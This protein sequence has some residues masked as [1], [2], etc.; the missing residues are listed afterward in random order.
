MDQRQRLRSVGIFAGYM[1]A[2]VVICMVLGWFAARIT[3]NRLLDDANRRLARVET[4]RS[5][6]QWHLHKPRDLIAGRA[7]GHAALAHNDDTLR[8]T[9][10]DGTPF[11]LGLPVE[12]A[13][14][15]A[16]WPIL[17]VQLES[18]APGTLGLIWGSDLTPTCQ[19]AVASALTPDTRTLRIDLR[20]LRW[21]PVGASQCPAPGVARMLR[22]TLQIPASA[23]AQL[24]S[25]ALLTTEPMMPAPGTAIDL[26][27]GHVEQAFVRG[28]NQAMPWFRLPHG[29][30]AENM[31]SLR[32]QLLARWPGALILPAGA[33]PQAS[34][35]I[36]RTTLW[37]IACVLYLVALAWLAARP[38]KGPPRAWLE[39]T[40][41]LL[42]PLW[43]VIGLH[44]GLYPT[45]LG[46][47]AFGGGLAY[48]FFIE[49]RHLPRLWRW[50]T[51][52][53]DWLWPSLTVPVTLVLIATR[54]HALHPL[55]LGH[56]LTYFA[57]AW[58]QQWLMLIV[59]LP[60]VEQ[61]TRH[62]T[63]PSIIAVA[64]LFALLHTPNGMLMQ[65]CFIAELWWAWCFRRSRSV[66]PIGLAHA[67]CALL[68]ES[69]LVGG[70]VRSLEVSARFFL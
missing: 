32:D 56:V 14:D 29:L 28:G 8:I 63:A 17:Q 59:L 23:S 16:H 19:I 20:S 62:R 7:F 54:G 40:G 25:A 38:I 30:S 46:I 11:E 13:L 34:P 6:W 1:L 2:A 37:W 53:R 45:A 70:L 18:S 65:L 26:P 9:S 68:V 41:C 57:W 44:W 60:R 27:S 66:L 5:L 43:L 15:L 31:L 49:R 24:T 4:G 48:A 36:S 39:I 58:L 50:P 35:P 55:P 10:Q 69:G 61:M 42:G 47:L 64:L 22:L 52:G 33:T 12:D 67:A 51:T 3:T 21:Q